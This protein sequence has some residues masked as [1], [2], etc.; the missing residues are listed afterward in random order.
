MLHIFRQAEV[1]RGAGSLHVNLSVVPTG[2]VNAILDASRHV[3]L[4][5]LST[6]VV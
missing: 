4:R 2:T 6:F 5:V 1:Q 3:V